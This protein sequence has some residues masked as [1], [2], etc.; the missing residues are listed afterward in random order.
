MLDWPSDRNMV[1]LL[2]LSVQSSDL[3]L[4]RVNFEETRRRRCRGEMGHAHE[5]V[6]GSLKE[7]VWISYGYLE[8][9]D[10]IVCRGAQFVVVLTYRPHVP[11][12][13]L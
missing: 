1:T 11:T 5:C 12:V 3:G 6:T 10:F 9:I 7:A 8:V 2:F 4:P 13:S